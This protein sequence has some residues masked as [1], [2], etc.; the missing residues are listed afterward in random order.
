MNTA[1]EPLESSEQLAVSTSAEAGGGPGLWSLTA[2][3]SFPELLKLERSWRQL[4]ARC[5]GPIEQFD[6]AV[7]CAQNK[8]DQPVEAIMVSRDGEPSALVPLAVRRF[9]GARRKAMLGVDDHH[10]PMDLL[11]ADPQAVEELAQAIAAQRWPLQFGRLPAASLAVSALRKAFRRRGLVVVRPQATFPYIPLHEGWQEPE[12]QL[13]SR[14]RSDFRRA[15]RKAEAAGTLTA[16]VRC[17]QADELDAL[18]E[19]AFA[20]EAK[21]WKGRA[22]TALAYNAEEAE[23][24]RSYAKAACQQGILRMAFLRIDGR[25]V[26]MQIAMQHGGGYWLLKIGY[27]AE[28]AF[29]SPGLI[30]LREA[31][32][33]AAQQGLQT[34]EFLGQSEPWIEVWTSHQRE[35][36]SLRVYPYNLRG[37]IALAA[38]AA[39]RAGQK[40]ASLARSAGRCTRSCLKA[41]AQPLIR[42]VARNYIAGE[43]LTDAVRVK[44]RLAATGLAATIGYWDGEADTPRTVADQYLAGLE[45]IAASQPLTAAEGG[46]VHDPSGVPC[47]WPAATVAP[48]PA[49]CGHLRDYLSIKLPALN[50]QYEL[51]REVAKK[52]AALGVRIHCDGMGP[53]SVDRTKDLI[54]QLKTELPEVALSCTLPG[55]WLRSVEDAAWTAKWQ[56]PVRV[57]KGEWP[58][59]LAP[60]R[61]LRAGYLEVI[62]ALAGKAPWVSVASHDPPLARQAIER[63]QKA[64]TPCDQELLFGLPSRVQIRQAQELGV[65]VRVYI[66]YGV[67]YMPYALSKVKRKPQI[68]WWLARDLVVSFF[69]RN[70]AAVANPVR[71]ATENAS[72]GVSTSE[73]AAGLNGAIETFAS[74]SS[75]EDAAEA[76]V[77][78]SSAG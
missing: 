67:A 58:D 19:E 74:E 23:F 31:I 45:A 4:G 48:L 70:D 40:A 36:V 38:D 49:V 22:G 20:V 46:M 17:P 28:Y 69:R 75:H 65:A 55:R 21:S 16:D 76:E 47:E 72:G 66:P 43:T 8:P 25:A 61:D 77:E 35:C 32:A 33:Y 2:V 64:G 11:Y 9:Y 15:R 6:W 56:L 1:L 62:D 12:S 37:A 29:C 3:H 18:L 50:Y 68:L 34:F 54:E 10:E 24:C 73:A 44:D 51:L 53:E 5:G 39:A 7:A 30:L 78:S 52:A 41:C 60:D 42:R 27:D 57:V 13:S 71:P 63:L 26:A 14:R 59:P